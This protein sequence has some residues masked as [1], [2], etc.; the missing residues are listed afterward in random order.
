MAFDHEAWRL[1]ARAILADHIQNRDDL[2][3][4]RDRRGKITFLC[5]KPDHEDETPS[6]FMGD[7]GWECK[8]CDT[9]GNLKHLAGILG[10]DLP[11]GGKAKEWPTG[12]S[13]AD[14]MREKNLPEQA[15]RRWGFK[16]TTYPFYDD[17]DAKHLLPALSFPYRDP[18]G[19]QLRRRF[20]TSRT[21]KRFKWGTGSN[22][23]LYGLDAVAF[24][25][26]QMPDA[27]MLIVEGESDC[28]AC[29]LH[30]L[31]ALG[32]PGA[33]DWPEAWKSSSEMAAPLLEGRRLY[34]WRE[35]DK[36]GK[37]FVD[38]VAVTFP[39][40]L[41]IDAPTGAKDPSALRLADVDAFPQAMQ[42][43]ITGAQPYQPPR[44]EGEDPG[45][46]GEKAPER[47]RKVPRPLDITDVMAIEEP[48]EVWIAEGIVP[49]RANVLLAAYPKSHKTNACLELA[50][51]AASETPFM[52]RFD[53]PRRHRVGLVLMEGAAHQLK[54][55]IGRLCHGRAV[56]PAE[57]QGL[58]K[59]WF[60]PPLRLS[61]PV[62]MAEIR[63]DVRDLA[64]DLLIVDNW[65]YVST[66]NS[67][68]ADEVTPQL[69]ALSRLREVSPEL[70]VL[71]VHHARKTTADKSA[72]RLTDLIRNSSAFGAWYD[73]GMAFSREGEASPVTVRVEMRDTPP[74]DSF[75]FEVQDEHPAGPD[76]GLYPTGWMRI[77][78]RS[79][80][81]AAVN[82]AAK[83]DHLRPKVLAYVVQNPGCT[84][85]SVKKALGG[86]QRATRECIDICVHD[87]ELSYTPPERAGLA[88]SLRITE[89][90]K[91]LLTG[92]NDAQN[93]PVNPGSQQLTDDRSVIP[94]FADPGYPGSTP[95]QPRFNRGSG[96]APG[97][98]FAPP[99]PLGGATEPGGAPLPR[100]AEDD[101]P[102]VMSLRRQYNRDAEMAGLDE[103]EY[104]VQ[105]LGRQPESADDYHRL[106]DAVQAMNRAE[107]AL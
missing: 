30:A 8:G 42:A 31:I 24:Y 46:D 100:P 2:Q 78:A 82:R 3:P 94:L 26:K 107:P 69:D 20:R 17:D 44:G 6:A 92:D 101:E 86:N 65:S 41:V 1:E 18:A 35:P 25:G 93:T 51:A 27:P 45:G 85:E 34:V 61:D 77:V 14:Y 55:R 98:R 90:G 37:A 40:V 52:G 10:V 12:Y 83:V 87:A 96:D 80:T 50:I 70:S 75:A 48:E 62:L 49:A 106:I 74:P 22:V 43:L 89:E 58:V 4:S 63:D 91:A 88:G 97:P 84:K 28:H 7:R 38:Q 68:D 57:L 73:V 103:D 102:G 32:V 71:L 15:L 81:P 19:K 105:T 76:T 72:E 21:G 29:W 53:V 60:R 9:K 64:L 104:A 56:A 54:R 16:D 36:G 33:S 79:G 99:A 67:N 95:V 59:V 47:E 13:L 5:P 23:Y 11:K 66:G 39:D